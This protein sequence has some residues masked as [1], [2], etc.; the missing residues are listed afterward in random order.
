MIDAGGGAIVTISSALAFSGR[1]N[2]AHYTSS[3]GGSLR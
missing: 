1:A 3:K 2:G